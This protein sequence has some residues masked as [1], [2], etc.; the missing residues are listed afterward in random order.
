MSELAGRRG[1]KGFTLIELLVVIIIIGILAAIAI[2]MYLTGRTRAKDAAVK[3]G[4]HA[5]R[6]GV[7]SWAVDN[8]DTY[9][10]VATVTQVNLGS[11][12]DHWPTNPYSPTAA[13]MANSTTVGDYRYTQGTGATSYLLLGNLNTGTFPAN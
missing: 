3:E 13:Y 10:P 12:V 9:P 7:Q 8:D 6:V 1:Q 5:I 2:P 11:Y 4:V